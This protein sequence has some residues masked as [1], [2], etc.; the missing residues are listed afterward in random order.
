MKEDSRRRG[1]LK[2]EKKTK[3]K[4][5]F[6]EMKRLILKKKKVEIK[7]YWKKKEARKLKP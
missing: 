2:D 7:N 3:M 6:F 5:D 1:K 4:R